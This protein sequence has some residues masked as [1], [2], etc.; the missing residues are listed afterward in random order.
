MIDGG[1]RLNF[2]ISGENVVY[3]K[4]NHRTTTAVAWDAL[5]QINKLF[6]SKNLTESQKLILAKY[7]K[8]L[9]GDFN[10]K[11]EQLVYGGIGEQAQYVAASNLK[12]KVDSLAGSILRQAEIPSVF[13][14]K[15]NLVENSSNEGMVLR[16]QE[17]DSYKECKGAFISFVKELGFSSLKENDLKEATSYFST[18]C[19]AL[20]Q[21]SDLIVPQ[22]VKWRI[23]NL[24]FGESLGQEGATELLTG[25]KELSADLK[26]IA[27]YFMFCEEESFKGTLQ[28]VVGHLLNIQNE[29]AEA[30]G[31]E[32]LKF[33]AEQVA[34]ST[35]SSVQPENFLKVKKVFCEAYLEIIKK[36]KEHLRKNELALAT[37]MLR[38]NLNLATVLSSKIHYIAARKLGYQGF[39]TIGALNYLHDLEDVAKKKLEPQAAKKLFPIDY[40]DGKSIERLQEILARADL[41]GIAKGRDDRA[42]QLKTIFKNEQ[43]QKTYVENFLSSCSSL[44]K[45]GEYSFALQKD[46][47]ISIVRTWKEQGV[48]FDEKSIATFCQKAICNNTE[49]DANMLLALMQKEGLDA[50]VE[51]SQSSQVGFG[52]FGD[53]STTDFSLEEGNKEKLVKAFEKLILSKESEIL[54][55]LNRCNVLDSDSRKDLIS[56]AVSQGKGVLATDLEKDKQDVKE[57]ALQ[58]IQQEP[59]EPA[60]WAALNRALNESVWESEDRQTLLG[61]CKSAML[62]NDEKKAIEI[63][64]EIRGILP[65]KSGDL[66]SERALLNEEEKSLA[67]LAASNRKPAVFKYFVNESSRGSALYKYQK[68]WFAY[69]RARFFGIR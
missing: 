46:V 24:N 28:N 38:R 33:L 29:L 58:L 16:L 17:T 43:S 68:R 20:E 11:Y 54:K 53:I 65:E 52:G 1:P 3:N 26:G 27:E 63:I 22:E 30:L 34:Q 48:K 55:F 41:S 18:F 56:F 60:S 10:E 45:K 64:K 67:Q 31:K 39:S 4:E 42:L 61:F 5:G 14:E 25:L 50:L 2:K 32:S 23:R 6:S 66:G 9:Q 62:Y 37:E 19:D 49:E 59:K 36:A 12:R 8:N 69:L 13:L 40:S 15:I 51:H 47:F 7:A 35:A 44:R 21:V 57:I